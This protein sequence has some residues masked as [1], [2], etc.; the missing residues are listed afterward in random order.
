MGETPNWGLNWITVGSNSETELM[1]KC[2]GGKGVGTEGSGGSRGKDGR[3]QGE[4]VG[5]RRRWS[6]SQPPPQQPPG[7]MVILTLCFPSSFAPPSLWQPVSHLSYWY[8]PPSPPI[9]P[10][11]PPISPPSPPISRLLVSSLHIIIF[12]YWALHLSIVQVFPLDNRFL[13]LYY[14]QSGSISLVLIDIDKIFINGAK[15]WMI[16]WQCP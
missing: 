3:G 14:S 7:D 4:G 15:P 2:W 12:W 8:H 9:S 5:G 1:W 6:C 16:S 11:F 10:P 13:F